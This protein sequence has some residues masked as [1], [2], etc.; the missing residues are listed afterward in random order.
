MDAENTTG[1]AFIGATAMHEDSRLR[2]LDL[3]AEIEYSRRKLP[4]WFQPGVATFVT[5]RT[6]DSMPQAALERWT[7]QQQ[8][9][10]KTHQVDRS[11]DK[12]SIGK[13]S[14][15]LRQQFKRFRISS[16]NKL[17]DKAYGQCLL[18]RRDVARI[19]AETLWAFDGQRYDLDCFVI[20]PNHVH[21]LVGFRRGWE[22]RAQCDNWLHYSALKINQ[23]L[24]SSGSVWQPEPFDHCVRSLEQF[25]WTRNYIWRNP[26][27]AR[28]RK[29]EYVH[30]QSPSA[31]RL[32]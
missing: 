17:L 30:W 5:F 9:F 16:F 26:H 11:L 28:L 21:V 12:G 19:V 20:M 15:S 4:H 23:L 14:P 13:L 27:V 7:E 25:E 8:L 6:I 22:L 2:A 1:L 3:E 32:T 29:D 24:G 18:R 31:G 10:L